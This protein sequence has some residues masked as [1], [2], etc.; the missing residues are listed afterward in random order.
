MDYG[1]EEGGLCGVAADVSAAGRAKLRLGL[2]DAGVLLVE[3]ALGLSGRRPSGGVAYV[4]GYCPLY[5]HSRVGGN[6]VLPRSSIWTPAC[7]G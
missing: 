3:W 7:A 2:G 6:P 5:R 1:W 4:P